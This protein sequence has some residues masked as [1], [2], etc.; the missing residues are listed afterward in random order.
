MLVDGFNHL[1]KYESQWKGLSHILWTIKNSPNHSFNAQT[2]FKSFD[3]VSMAKIT[4]SQYKPSF[5][6]T[7]QIL[8]EP[9]KQE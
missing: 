7:W 4:V 2:L 5:T 9:C 3:D 6:T 8:D 1:E